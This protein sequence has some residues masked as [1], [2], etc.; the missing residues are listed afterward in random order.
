MRPRAQVDR[1]HRIDR[2]ARP[3]DAERAADAVAIKTEGS[4]SGVFTATSH[5]SGRHLEFLEQLRR[6]ARRANS[7][8]MPARGVEQFREQVPLRA[9]DDGVP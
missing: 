2:T 3:G 9:L 1:P 7:S 6:L 4:T 8:D 5:A